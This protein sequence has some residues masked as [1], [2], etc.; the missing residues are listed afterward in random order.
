[1]PP[2][3]TRRTQ[4]TA[5]SPS[6]ARGCRLQPPQGVKGRPSDACGLPPHARPLTA[7]LDRRLQLQQV[8]LAHEYLLGRQAEEPNLVL[9][10]LNLFTGPSIL[11]FEQ[12]LYQV[13]QLA[14]LEVRH[15]LG[16]L[17]RPGE[18]VQ[19]QPANTIQ[20]V[21]GR[22][23]CRAFKHCTPCSTARNNG[24]AGAGGGKRGAGSTCRAGARAPPPQCEP[25]LRPR[26]ALPA[27]RAQRVPRSREPPCLP[28]PLPGRQAGRQGCRCAHPGGVGRRRRHPAIHARSIPAPPLRASS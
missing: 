18:A 26:P 17:C 28:L 22:S 4:T 10:Q 5:A 16:S 14:R 27:A 23:A 1:M 7:D 13:V 6:T 15:P 9:A 2:A 20:L 25:S 3:E 8:W 24:Q 19:G 12:P 11:D 21:D